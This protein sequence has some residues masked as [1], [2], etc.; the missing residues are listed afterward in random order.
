M[1]TAFNHRLKGYRRSATV[2]VASAIGTVIGGE[3]RA[4]R[5]LMR[6]LFIQQMDPSCRVLVEF[7]THRFMVD[8]RDTQVGFEL[9]RG[10]DWQRKELAGAIS[11]LRSA[12][13]LPPDKAF[14][15][16]GANIGTQTVYA[17]LDGD[18][19]RG[20]A[21]EV[22]AQNF[23][24]LQRNLELN[25]LAGRVQAFH[26]AASDVSG[27][28]SLSLDTSNAG[29]HAIATFASRGQ[30]LEVAAKPL[31]L[32]MA[33]AGLPAADAGLIWMD[34]EGH[35]LKVL[36]GMKELLAAGVP[37]VIE[38]DAANHG[39]DAVRLLKTALGNLYTT[40][41]VL[42]DKSSGSAR[43]PMP[44]ENFVAPPS[45]RDLLIY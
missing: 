17:F 33:D 1:L 22:E 11:L 12:G 40:L 44:I 24:L 31:D 10:R 28:L 37:L 39:Q 35:E 13:R 21:V 43:G 19:N 32:M 27:T 7:K 3:K 45:A 2:S 9:M 36:A 26:M 4:C 18:F 20:M 25:G 30:M 42:N 8:P 15:D 23:A 5:S 6:Q 34:V 38:F 29:G 41:A 14:I 16:V